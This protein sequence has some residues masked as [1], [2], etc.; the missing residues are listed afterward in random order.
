MANSSCKIFVCS[1]VT[2]EYIQT[3]WNLQRESGHRIE[4]QS[5]FCSVEQP[6]QNNLTGN[7]M[8]S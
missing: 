2:I 8:S 7:G 6:G 1:E 4:R 5:C 3:I